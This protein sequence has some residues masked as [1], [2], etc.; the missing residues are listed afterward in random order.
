MIILT[1][2]GECI[3]QLL[4][5]PFVFAPAACHARAALSPSIR[6]LVL[7]TCPCPSH[8][9]LPL[10]FSA[11]IALCSPLV[12]FFPMLRYAGS[13]LARHVRG[14]GALPPAL[15][16]PAL[17]AA[18]AYSPPSL[19]LGGALPFADGRRT[20]TILAV[21]RGNTVAV[22]G[23]GQVT[24]GGTVMKP[25]A[26]KVRRLGPGGSV[27]AGF[28]GATAD[29][30]TL[31]ERL[32]GKI[33]AH[34]G[35]LLRAAVALAAEWRLDK[36]L[37]RL[38]AVM[39]VVDAKMSLT[40]TGGGDVLEPCDGIVGVGS[41][42]TAAIAAA[43]AL[44][45]VADDAT[46]AAA[47]RQESSDAAGGAEAAAGA[48]EMGA[49]EMARRAMKIAADMCVYTNDS[50]VTEVIVDEE[51]APAATAGGDTDA[52]SSKG[53]AD[54]LASTAAATPVT[55]DS[56]EGVAEG[57]GGKRKGKKGGGGGT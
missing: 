12:A 49:E 35:Q 26:R 51:G 33:D 21:R 10:S 17:G 24:Q 47:A 11:L 37:R 41:G 56:E 40:L 42:G 38:D 39:I 57:D 5:W 48:P 54:A 16:L 7:C 29:A 8:L 15:R 43:R 52:Q 28:A 13:S 9:S 31:L 32:E 36:Y 23:D 14:V 2:S 3:H 1:S 46:A 19:A 45:G 25:N 55:S 34:P 44:M 30:M 53:A 4:T 20:T 18:A 27:I 6:H 22:I 50:W